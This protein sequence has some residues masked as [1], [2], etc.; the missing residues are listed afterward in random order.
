MSTLYDYLPVVSPDYVAYFPIDSYDNAFVVGGEKNVE[1]HSGYSISEERIL[2]SPQTKFYINLQWSL[3]SEV[4]AELLLDFYHNPL[5]ACGTYRSFYFTPVSQYSSVQHTYVVR[6][7]SPLEETFSNVK[8]YGVG[9]LQLIVLG[10][11]P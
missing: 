9:N 4:D 2:F 8:R 1:I 11:K 6:F 3:M 5:K 7:N 10:R